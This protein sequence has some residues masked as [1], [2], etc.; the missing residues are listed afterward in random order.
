MPPIDPGTGWVDPNPPD[1]TNPGAGRTLL[2]SGIALTGVVLLAL[3]GVVIA[4][5]VGVFGGSGDDGGGGPPVVL[6]AAN[7]PGENAFMPSTVV[8]P[9]EIAD[10]VAGDIASFV[11]QLPPSAARGAR[12]V[13]GTQPGLYGAFGATAVC[14]VPAVANYL[15]A[16]PERS[17]P[18][19]QSIGVA[20]QKIPYYL[21]T[22]TP[23][24][25]ITD[26]WVTSVGFIE[27]RATPEQTVLQAGNAVLVDRAGVPRVRCADGNPLAPS[28]N[29]DLRT[30]DAQGKNW[31][32][33]M[34]E[35][36]VAVSYA[37]TGGTEL[38]EEF[39]L[40]DLSSGEA[41]AYPPGGTINLGP[42]PAGWSPDPVAMNVPPEG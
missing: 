17:T 12:M 21:N 4:K 40:R 3:V 15:D 2:L 18:W 6:A 37:G 7:Q 28:A 39:T 19:A 25:L 42:D 35:N 41:Q 31:D 24:A 30:L 1:T 22:L 13:P 16:H 38:V 9:I 27:G 32:E 29:V 8:A 36:V 14:D 23:V 20:P 33:Y 34:P 11:A 10:T 5:H 26:T